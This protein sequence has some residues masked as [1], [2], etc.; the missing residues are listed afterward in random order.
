MAILQELLHP[1]VIFDSITTRIKAPNDTIQRF[2]GWQLGGSN[3]M[4]IRGRAGVYDVFD[5]V[6]EVGTASLPATPATQ[7]AQ[8][9]IAQHPVMLLRKNEKISLYYDSLHNMRVLGK[10]SSTVDRGGAQYIEEQERRL[11]MQFA[12]FREFLSL[13]IMRGNVYFTAAGEQLNPT[14]TSTG[15]TL[16]I[17]QQIPTSHT[18]GFSIP[19]L[20]SN[21]ASALIF[22]DI[23]SML[24][25]VLADSGWTLKHFWCT[26]VV[27]EYLTANTDMRARA[28]T[29]NV[30]FENFTG[31]GKPGPDDKQADEF[32]S[33][34]RPLPNLMFH[35]FPNVLSLNAVNTKLLPDNQIFGCPEPDQSWCSCLQG[36]EYVAEN[37]TNPPS[38]REL[39]YFWP[40]YQRD[41]AKID[42][43]GLDVVMP[44]L[45][46]PKSVVI[47]TIA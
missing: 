9:A 47:P 6:R 45:R 38:E 17:N 10:P 41:P 14:F 16:N 13:S 34:L 11:K 25:T 37:E 33:V 8:Y 12:A 7:I 30:T 15:A 22:N 39:P 5:L 26:E 20:W 36:T 46:V 24:Q 35:V 21:T 32:R 18:S 29:S 2:F 1:Q 19:I 42:I 44:V 23:M 3:I 43:V 31:L 28:G 27:Y 4:R 40:W